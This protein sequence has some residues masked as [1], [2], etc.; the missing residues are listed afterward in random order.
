MPKIN[1][2]NF[3]SYESPNYSIINI[4]KDKNNIININNIYMPNE[5]ANNNCSVWSKQ[6]SDTALEKPENTFVSIFL[7]A[8]YTLTT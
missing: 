3:Y 6:A 5:P 1:N 8:S 2:N 7:A 4:Q